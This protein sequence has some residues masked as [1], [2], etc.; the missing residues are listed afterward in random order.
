MPLI[1]WIRSTAFVKAC[2]VV[3]YWCKWIWIFNI[4]KRR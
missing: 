4:W 2:T 1:V 3:C